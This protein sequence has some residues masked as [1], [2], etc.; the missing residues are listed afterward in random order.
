M[1]NL[2]LIVKGTRLCNLRCTYCNDWRSGHDQIMN[3]DVLAHMIYKALSDADS[4]VVDFIWHGGE[5]TLLPISFYERA[6][7]VQAQFRRRKQYI[8]NKIQTNGTRLTSEW[9]D[10]LTENRFQI[11]V[12]IDGPP[13]IHNEHRRYVSGRASFDDIAGGLQRLRDAGANFGVLMV[14]GEQ[15]YDLGP[16]R[17][18]RFFVDADVKNFGLL[19]ARPVNQPAT[20]RSLNAKPYISP[21]RFNSFL[22]RLYDI[23]ESHGD[24]TV[25]IRELDLLRKRLSDTADRPCT[26]AG[27]CIGNYFMVDPS[28]EV[29]HCDLFLGDSNYRLGNVLNDDF[30]AV[31]L[32][33]KMLSLHARNQR[34]LQSLRACPEF[35]V[36]NGWCP[37]SRYLSL[38]HNSDHRDDCCGLSDLIAH[39]RSRM[40][41]EVPGQLPCVQH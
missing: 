8:R 10:F 6:L 34:E 15:A 36:C 23:W 41:T 32:S 4:E 18:F 1:G 19:P 14:I 39:I 21:R 24:P 12:S 29:A 3:F 13:E 33:A 35:A 38:R 22:I 25:I 31:R 40:A 27:G 17:I 26:L 20:T 28:G 37:H 2:T 16:E 5:T 9:I 30:A 7:L 11:G